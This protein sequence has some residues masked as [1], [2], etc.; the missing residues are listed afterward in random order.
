MNY[1]E[2]EKTDL[3]AL[4][5]ILFKLA[6]V[7]AFLLIISALLACF[8]KFTMNKKCLGLFTIFFMLLFLG[9]GYISVILMSSEQYTQEYFRQNCQLIKQGKLSEMSKFNQKLFTKIEQMDR[10][11]S[12][13]VNKNMCTLQ[14]PCTESFENKKAYMDLEENF[15]EK[16]S[17][18][19]NSLQFSSFFSFDSL[20]Q[21]YEYYDKNVFKSSI[22]FFISFVGGLDTSS[23]EI[24]PKKKEFVKYLEENY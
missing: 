20:L 8:V 15:F 11:I 21:C 3:Q 1:V 13:A 4:N 18:Q 19:K 9:F 17:R 10:N 14:C 6:F 24:T 7:M 23:F 12:S 16:F 2:I 22:S 5:N